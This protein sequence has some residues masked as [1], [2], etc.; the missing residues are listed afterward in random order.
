MLLQNLPND[1]RYALRS[2][3]RA[4]GLAAAAIVTIA[5]G[6]GVNT[7]IFSIINGVLFRDIPAPDG[8]ELVSI[9][10]KIGGLPERESARV[11]LAT[12]AEF[13]TYHDRAKTLSAL[14]GHSDPIGALLRG[15]TAQQ[16]AGLLVTC[17]YF[18]VLHEQPALGRALT[19]RDCR[20][21]ADPV[22]VLGHEL[23][24]GTFGADPTVVGRTI[25]LGRRLFTVVGIAREGTYSGMFRSAFFAPISTQPLLLPSA[26]SYANDRAGWLYLV[27][28]RNDGVNID[29]VR[30]ELGVI[31]AGI[32]RQEPG[33][34]TTLSI[35]RAKPLTVPSFVRG[36]ALGAGAVIMAAFV[37]ILL[38]ACANVANLMLA[39]GAARSREIAVRL[40]LGASRA[41]V[42]R[43]L[44]IESILLA[45]A[46]GGLG[47]L[48]AL[49]SFKTLFAL[50]LPTVTPV[51]LP[52]FGLD[53][54]P[55]IRVL[56]ITVALTF[57]TG[58]LFGLAPA[59]HASKPDLHSVMKQDSRGGGSR[60]SGR[61]QATLVGAQVA[62]CM[63]L[64]IGAGLL[65]RG[66]HAAH[67][68]DPGFD[69]RN[70]SV[71]SYDY[72]SDTGH[73]PDSA[74]WPQ[75]QEQIAALP[76]VEATAYVV[77]DPIG[78]DYVTG[79]LRLPGAGDDDVRTSELNWVGPGYFSVL[80]VPLVLGRTFG[81]T[82]LVKDSNVAI[83]SES[84][85]RNLWH[86]GD[87]IGR[88]LLWRRPRDK[89]IELTI[90]GVAKDAQVR[91]L[92]QTDPY[93]V[94]LPARVGDKL[95]VKSRTDFATTAAAI[96]DVVRA[97]DPGLP[98][99]M[100]PLEAN[101][102]RSRNVSGIVT[103]LAAALG[104]LALILAA[105]GIYGVVSHF[106]GQRIREIGIRIALGAEAPK[107][108][109]LI[110]KRTMRPV[111]VGAALGIAGGIGV[112]SVLSSMLFGVSPVDTLALVGSILF[113]LGVALM[114][115]GAVARR[116]TR[117][118]PMVT[119]RHE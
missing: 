101:L 55:D 113:V 12:T 29:Q 70:V 98:V 88:T 36:V 119:L 64:M 17:S 71:L 117:V 112:S 47:S 53:V 13:Q 33:R 69:Y 57:G 39:R 74:F 77:R 81:D 114:S 78:E 45:I 82:D 102:E 96:R 75:L 105:V 72:V 92:G 2:L 65:L 30:A 10:Q 8:H 42:I 11:G 115:G 14:A 3:S 50:A 48:L 21:G 109:G 19:D 38:I 84:T 61:L 1:L 32:D 22:V 7:G 100:Y 110:L 94:Y 68:V 25:D 5:L 24:A 62:L 28:R 97:L 116:A 63:V 6:V 108:V 59:L 106:V 104:A 60:R 90:V 49:G 26:N 16:T 23:W 99:P 52:P 111:V 80:G 73:A 85:A 20:V 18:E 27:G 15:D 44:L 87:A 9:D 56:A 43:Q 103:T 95:L 37:F 35:E 66:L 46:G 4:P 40:S 41:R 79:A 86:G 89:E 67:T 34:S 76:G 118:D 83:V 93:Y 107:V 51:G 91:S 58:V 31:A 54:S